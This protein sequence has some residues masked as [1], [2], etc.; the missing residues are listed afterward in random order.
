MIP[1]RQLVEIRKLASQS[2]ESAEGI[3]QLIHETR[4]EI[5]SVSESMN[6]TKHEA[7]TG[8]TMMQEVNQSFHTIMESVTQI[9][10]TSAITQQISASSEQIS[11]TM[12]HSASS[13]TNILMK[14]QGVAAATEEQLAI[15][16]N[17]AAASEQLRSVV[18]TLNESVSY[19]KIA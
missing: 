6:A 14:S 15:M 18:N 10:E 19:F 8:S 11:A 7:S 13:S 16:Q 4:V 3:N 5:A 9:H 2:I 12:D 1:S 17:I